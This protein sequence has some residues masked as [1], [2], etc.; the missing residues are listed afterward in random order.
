MSPQLEVDYYEILSVTR[1]AS[2]DQIKSAYRKAALKWHPDRNPGNT[3]AAEKFR[4]CSDAYSVLSDPQKRAVYDRYGHAGLKNSGFG[5]GSGINETIFEEFQDIL[6]D[7]FGFEGAFGGG[8]GGRRGRTQRGQRG[9]DLRYDLSLT[10][11]EAASGVTSKIKLDRFENCEAC[12]GTG[13]KVGTGMTTCKTCGGRG[14]MSYQQGFFSITRTC[15]ACQGTGQTIREACT[16]CRGQGKMQR[17]RT[18]E[19]GV[20]AGVD[21]GTR[22]RMAGQGEP[23]TNGGPA[24]DLYIFLEVKEHPLF[25]RRG[26]DLYCTVPISFPQAALGAKIKI[27]TLHGEEDL[28][29]PEGTQS[30]QLF[31]KKTKGLPNPHGGRGDLYVNVRVVVPTKLSKEHKRALEQLGQTMKVDNKP[32]ERS[33]SFFDKVKD[34]FG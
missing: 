12:K 25:E 24:G 10:F 27:P 8:G 5:G 26:A 20:P 32:T 3:E 31:L 17:E 33:S 13:A 9:T 23:G 4:Q 14:Q 29:V 28:E 30:G 15:P 22:L 34:I 6:G 2:G 7:F 18:L 21:S 11:E 16:S 19:V 1:D